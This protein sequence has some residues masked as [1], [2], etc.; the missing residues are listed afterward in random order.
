M[1]R[2]VAR[3][4]NIAA[5]SF[6]IHMCE[7]NH[8]L[9]SCQ[10]TTRISSLYLTEQSLS[11]NLRLRRTARPLQAGSFTEGWLCP[12]LP[13][14]EAA[15]VVFCSFKPQCQVLG[16]RDVDDPAAQ[17]CGNG[18]ALLT[19]LWRLRGVCGGVKLSP[20]ASRPLV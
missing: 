19:E 6:A 14:S 3:V 17:Q 11:L 13:S 12:Q 4:F 1:G 8:Q 20:G 15:S 16:E 9:L 2:L 10:T 7:T 5:K 18:S